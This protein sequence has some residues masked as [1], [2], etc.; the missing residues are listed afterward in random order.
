[1]SKY[2]VS[3]YDKPGS[4][5]RATRRLLNESEKSL[6]ILSQELGVPFYWL[7]AFRQNRIASPSVN[8]VQ[9]IYEKLSGKVIALK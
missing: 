7:A 5:I 3:P 4:L 2:I 1:M 9:Y 8:R 6:L